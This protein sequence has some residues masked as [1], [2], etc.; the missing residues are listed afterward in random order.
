MKA[1]RGRR[2][3][4]LS[5]TSELNAGGWLTP[6]PGRFS[7]GKGLGFYFSDRFSSRKYIL[8][9]TNKNMNIKISKQNGTYLIFSVY[10][11]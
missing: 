11:L 7:P 9:N 1:R 6:S 2:G 4:P 10:F 5:L 8:C 3:I